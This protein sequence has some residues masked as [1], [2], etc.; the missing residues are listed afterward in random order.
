MLLCT[1]FNPCEA[2]LATTLAVLKIV[3]VLITGASGV[4]ALITETKT[5]DKR[6]LTKAGR[7]LLGL[8]VIGFIVAFGAQL[9][10]SYKAKADDDA[11]KART[12]KL[13]KEI[14]RAV[15]RIDSISM[16][17][18]VHWPIEEPALSTYRNRLQEL[19]EQADADYPKAGTESHGLKVTERNPEHV[20]IFTI[21]DGSA[22]FPVS[23]DGTAFELFNSAAHPHIFIYKQA[24]DEDVLK[25][26]AKSGLEPLPRADLTLIPRGGRRHTMIVT[27]HDFNT[28]TPF[29]I[30]D[31]VTGL[32]VPRESWSQSKE[33]ISLTDLAGATGIIL[34]GSTLDVQHVF[35]APS[36]NLY[37]NGSRIQINPSQLKQ[38]KDHWATLYVFTLP[39]E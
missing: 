37:F 26:F 29:S 5:T 14:A 31:N 32:E 11:S 27:H 7:L 30:A 36:V 16:D 20:N 25:A 12:E 13:L 23:S 8:G 9:T 1:P 22:A 21:P 3:G 39:K 33:A 24:P 18:S 17:V 35:G 2:H 4:L 15:T 34:I 28:E 6:H 19:I 10:E 38:Y